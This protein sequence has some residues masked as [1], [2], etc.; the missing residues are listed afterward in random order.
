MPAAPVPGEHGPTQEEKLL[1]HCERGDCKAVV[2]VLKASPG[3]VNAPVGGEASGTALHQAAM[4]GHLLMTQQLLASKAEIASTCYMGGLTPLH[5]AAEEDQPEVCFELVAQKASP[6]TLDDLG[7]TPAHRAA[8]AGAASALR[9]LLSCGANAGLKDA[10]NSTPLHYAAYAGRLKCVKAICEAQPETV[11]LLGGGDSGT[12]LHMA[13]AAGRPEVLKELLSTGAADI[14]LMDETRQ[15][16][17]HRAAAGCTLST[18]LLLA[19]KADPAAEDASRWTPL[20]Y[21]CEYDLRDAVR[22]LLA[23]GAKVESANQSRLTPLHV[24][25][26]EGHVLTCAILMAAKADP[27]ANPGTGTASALQLARRDPA[28]NADLLA[29]FEMGYV[30][31]PATKADLLSLFETGYVKDPSLDTELLTFFDMKGV[32]IPQDSSLSIHAH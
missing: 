15:T 22:A 32:R 25:A 31:D 18:Q 27:R 13:A 21:A 6:N 24:A 4:R 26:G 5:L 7:Q 1:F 14:N 9:V 16:A 12:A 28:T 29:L 19:H 8:F 17:L 10:E 2:E 3:V 30:K 20:H 23:A 11:D